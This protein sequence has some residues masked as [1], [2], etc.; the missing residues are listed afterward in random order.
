[1]GGVLT[2]LVSWQWVFWFLLIFE[3]ALQLA[4]MAL[5][6]RPKRR[7]SDSEDGYSSPAQTTETKEG[8]RVVWS[9]LSSR[10]DLLG[11]FLSVAG[12][13]LLI[14]GLTTGIE[15]GWK[16]GDVIST[17]VIGVVLLAVFGFVEL[18]VA[19]HPLLPRYLWKDTVKLSGCG[20]AALTYAVW[21]GVNYLLTLELQDFGFSA[22]DTALRFLPLGITAFIVNVVVPPMLKPVGPRILLIVSWAL[23]VAGI[24]LLILMASAGDYWRLGLPGMILYTAGIA[25]VYYLGN[26]LVVA[27]A[28]SED[29]GTISG[30]YNVS[31]AIKRTFYY[32][33]LY[34]PLCKTL[35]A[36]IITDIFEHWRCSVGR[37]SYH[38]HH[39]LGNLQQ[40]WRRTWVRSP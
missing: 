3:G 35:T 36:L 19:A 2:S 16:Q 39:Q 38:R 8:K 21:M 22:L 14:Y 6:I 11:V 40:R 25:T 34:Y 31:L 30:V 7:S 27:T 24:V 32:E 12:L 26:V 20:L 15:H 17:L 1:M 29:Q 5:F 18:H 23:A 28:P 13:V 37:R 33:S 4:A 10:T 9:E